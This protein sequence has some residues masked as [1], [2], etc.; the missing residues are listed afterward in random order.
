MITTAGCDIVVVC[1]EQKDNEKNAQR[2]AASWTKEVV[3]SE[4]LN[5]HLRKQ[6]QT[7]ISTSYLM[8]KIC[9]NYLVFKLLDF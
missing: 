8:C 1:I 6:V 3:G 7:L 9:N 4:A 2:E 5:F